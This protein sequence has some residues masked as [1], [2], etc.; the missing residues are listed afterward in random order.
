VSGSQPPFGVVVL[1]AVRLAW[2][3][4]ETSE[5]DIHNALH[6]ARFDVYGSDDGVVKPDE[7]GT[8]ER[9]VDSAQGWLDEFEQEREDAIEEAMRVASDLDLI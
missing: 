6:E 4:P 8:L 3:N 5:H 9:W 7:P 2:R 1:A